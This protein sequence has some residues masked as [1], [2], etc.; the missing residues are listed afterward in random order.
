MVQQNKVVAGSSAKNQ[1]CV[2]LVMIVLLL[3][4]IDG[5]LAVNVLVL[6]VAPVGNPRF[7]QFTT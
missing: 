5:S 6:I 4:V 7:G 1:D 3:K 2:L